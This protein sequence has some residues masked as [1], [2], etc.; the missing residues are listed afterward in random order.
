MFYTPKLVMNAYET[1]WTELLLDWVYE[2][3][4]SSN[5][6]T[7][8]SES[9]PQVTFALKVVLTKIGP[10]CGSNTGYVLA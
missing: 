1:Y 10:T 2:L 5:N 3:V 7:N 9:I 4:K 6:S 8:L